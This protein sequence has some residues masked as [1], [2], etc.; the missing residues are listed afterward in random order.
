MVVAATVVS[1]SAPA[2]SVEE[3]ACGSELAAL[4]EQA[5]ADAERVLGEPALLDVSTTVTADGI[6]GTLTFKPDGREPLTRQVQGENC[7]EVIEALGFAFQLYLDGVRASDPLRNGEDS[8]EANKTSDAEMR[9]PD[10]PEEDPARADRAANDEAANDPAEGELGTGGSAS[11]GRGVARPPRLRLS[12]G[13]SAD[14]SY[15]R[16]MALGLVLDGRYRL[17]REHWLGVSVGYAQT[18]FFSPS[19]DP[20]QTDALSFGL[21]WVEMDRIGRSQFHIL[22]E[23]GPRLSWLDVTSSSPKA[24]GQWAALTGLV[25]V[26][27]AAEVSSRVSLDLG[28]GAA[29]L[30]FTGPIPTEINKGQTFQSHSVGGFAKL[31]VSALF[32]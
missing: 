18:G 13:P 32:Q 25:A 22:A 10:P 12:I 17:W 7:A 15:A 29:V 8:R 6:L 23:A 14:W 31:G 9:S 26:G 1:V 21:S 27:L 2:Q 24:R 28:I 16:D 4:E 11:R 3:M 5:S 19:T 20:L 30:L